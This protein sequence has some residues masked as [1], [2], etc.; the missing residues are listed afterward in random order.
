M[1]DDDRRRH[2]YIIGK[3]GSGKSHFIRYMVN[4]DVRNGKGVCVID[5]HGDLADAV[6]GSIPKNRIDDVIYFNPSDIDRPMGLNML[7]VA[8]ENMRDFAVQEMI[9]VFLDAVPTGNDRSHV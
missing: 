5:P 8:D 3:T 7:E 4:Q 1:Q 2:F 9:S 6:L